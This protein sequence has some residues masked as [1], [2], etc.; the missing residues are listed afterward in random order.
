VPFRFSDFQPDLR[1][2]KM[3]RINKIKARCGLDVHTTRIYHT[4]TTRYVDGVMLPR[5]GTARP[6]ALQLLLVGL[7]WTATILNPIWS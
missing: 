3:G 6:F 7:I 5:I 2:T 1:G 4:R